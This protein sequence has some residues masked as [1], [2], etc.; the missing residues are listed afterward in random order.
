MDGWGFCNPYLC[1]LMCKHLDVHASWPRPGSQTPL[2]ESSAPQHYH[3]ILIIPTVPAKLPCLSGSLDTV[4]FQHLRPSGFHFSAS[5]TLTLKSSQGNVDLSMLGHK[6]KCFR[7]AQCEGHTPFHKR[8]CY[9]QTLLNI[10]SLSLRPCFHLVLRCVLFDW[11]TSGRGRHILFSPGVLI[12]LFC[13]LSTTSALISSRV[14]FM[15]G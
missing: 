12:R 2:Q 13:P 7:K 15:D 3:S 4:H 8:G 5:F 14:G 11:I 9:S 1:R 6:E 10:F